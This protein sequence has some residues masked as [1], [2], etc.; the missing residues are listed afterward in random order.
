MRWWR[1]T[2]EFFMTTPKK[3]AP[4]K[5][6][7]NPA[8][9]SL[10]KRAKGKPKKRTAAGLRQRQNASLAAKAKRLAKEDRHFQL[11]PGPVVDEG[12]PDDEDE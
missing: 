9:V 4:A 6:Q 10:G 2:L 8:A 7:K 1:V 5:A 3:K 11:P 12:W